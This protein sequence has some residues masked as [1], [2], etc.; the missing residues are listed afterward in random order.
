MLNLGSKASCESEMRRADN[1]IKFCRAELEYDDLGPWAGR[2]QEALVQ[3]HIDWH[4]A[5]AA[6]NRFC[7]MSPAGLVQAS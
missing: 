7:Q 1:A 5:K 6:H 4:A 3:A 2:T